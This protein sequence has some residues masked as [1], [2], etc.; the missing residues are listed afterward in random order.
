MVSCLVVTIVFALL[1]ADS[2][3]GEADVVTMH[4]P[5]TAATRNMIG[6]A[7]IAKMK[8]DIGIKNA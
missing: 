3:V 7:E 2:L 4:V 1:A 6:A 8:N 5:D